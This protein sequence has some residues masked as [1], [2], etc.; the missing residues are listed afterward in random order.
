[1]VVLTKVSLLLPL[2]LIKGVFGIMEVDQLRDLH[3]EA[4]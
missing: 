4:S 3:T 1:M 2:F